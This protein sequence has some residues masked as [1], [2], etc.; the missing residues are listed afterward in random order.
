[1]ERLTMTSPGWIFLLHRSIWMRVC[2][3]F[4]FRISVW[5]ICLWF[6]PHP[7]RLFWGFG[8]S[9]S[10]SLM[11][12][13]TWDSL[14]ETLQLVTILFCPFGT[15]KQHCSWLSSFHVADDLCSAVN[16]LKDGPEWRRPTMHPAASVTSNLPAGYF[17]ISTAGLNMRRDV[18]VA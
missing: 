14:V 7:E 4:Y 1:M 17:L 18:F 13:S 12:P 3:G 2:E 16:R 15:Q 9:Y 5:A 10:S 11:S 6:D 8:L